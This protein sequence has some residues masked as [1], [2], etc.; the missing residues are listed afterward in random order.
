M[1]KYEVKKAF[2]LLE[3]VL[4]IP[5][6]V[7]YAEKFLLMMNVYSIKTRKLLGKAKLEELKNNCQEI[8]YTMADCWIDVETRMPDTENSV[9]VCV[10][11]RIGTAKY[12]IPS[13][14]HKKPR[15]F[16]LSSEIKDIEAEI[17][18]WQYIGVDNK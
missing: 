17:T 12:G 5:G 8:K 13:L 2:S 16:Y 14:R 10:H 6:D 1:E 15:W 9:L 11:G 18:S 3:R 4:L 7:V